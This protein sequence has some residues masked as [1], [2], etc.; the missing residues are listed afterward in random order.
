MG[1]REG[2]GDGEA[3]DAFDQARL[4]LRPREEVGASSGE[5]TTRRALHQ[6]LNVVLAHGAVYRFLSAGLPRAMNGPK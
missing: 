2:A 1:G 4:L 5:G 3:D 6:S